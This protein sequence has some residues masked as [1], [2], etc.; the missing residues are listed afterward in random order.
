MRGKRVGV[1]LAC[2]NIPSHGEGKKRVEKE[3]NET[4][5]SKKRKTQIVAII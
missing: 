2:I 3:E 5:W 1:W 4:K